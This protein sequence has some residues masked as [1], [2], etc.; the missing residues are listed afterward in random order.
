MNGHHYVAGTFAFYMGFLQVHGICI[1]VVDDF[2]HDTS[3][4]LTTIPLKVRKRERNIEWLSDTSFK[5][6]V[7]WH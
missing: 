6:V 5:K 3:Y 1:F 7:K 2:I 4:W